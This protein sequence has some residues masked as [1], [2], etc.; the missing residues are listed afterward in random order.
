MPN[1]EHHIFVCLNQR[2]ESANR[3]SCGHKNGKKLKSALK[4]AAKEAGL[5][6]RVRINESGCLD[7]CEHG[8]VMV[9]Y[10]EAVWYGFVDVDDV[11]QIV[12]EHLIGG[13][14]VERLRLPDSC[15]NTAHCPH[16]KG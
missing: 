14:P 12:S 8:P 5:K 1:F 2:D 16:R 3:P 11:Q 15:V 9:V 7:Q 4:D 13:Q 10:P 6:H